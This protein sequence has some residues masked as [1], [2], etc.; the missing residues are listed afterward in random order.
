MGDNDPI[1]S[2]EKK[3]SG[4]A[5]SDMEEGENA[6]KVSP[7]KAHVFVV[8]K[9]QRVYSEP[10]LDVAYNED[11]LD[12]ATYNFC[13]V[14][15]TRADRVIKRFRKDYSEVKSIGNTIFFSSSTMLY[16]VRNSKL[17]LGLGL[18]LLL[19][20]EFGF[21]IL[22]ISSCCACCHIHFEC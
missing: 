18:C 4:D 6:V 14:D 1:I 2:W 22:Q 3:S 21:S 11:S 16:R 15:Y 9:R 19:R 13:E 17:G 7:T 8:E 10:Y 20:K 12:E 5:A